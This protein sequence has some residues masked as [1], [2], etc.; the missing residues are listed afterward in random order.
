M[1]QVKGRLTPAIF[2]A[3]TKA[4]CNEG[5]L[6]AHTGSNK[7]APQTTTAGSSAQ[8]AVVQTQVPLTMPPYNFTLPYNQ[9]AFV[10]PIFATHLAQTVAFEARSRFLASLMNAGHASLQVETSTD[11]EELPEGQTTGPTENPTENN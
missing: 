4:R 2:E 10:N 9:M 6:P 3:A 5:T 1:H 7:E 11:Q 8:A